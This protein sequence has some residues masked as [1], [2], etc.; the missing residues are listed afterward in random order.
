MFQ[1]G[2]EQQVEQ[3][4]GDLEASQKVVEELKAANAQFE[5]QLSEVQ[6]AGTERE[7]QL[8]GDLMKQIEELQAKNKEQL[9]TL[10]QHTTRESSLNEE[11]TSKSCIQLPQSFFPNCTNRR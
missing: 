3:L 11:K 1:I 8:K 7:E 2:V 4:R 9:E 5:T 6:T 10:E